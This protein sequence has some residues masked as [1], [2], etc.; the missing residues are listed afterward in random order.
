LVWNARTLIAMGLAMWLAGAAAAAENRY[1]DM[2]SAAVK[3][4]EVMDPSGYQ[5]GLLFNPEGYRS[6]YVRSACFQDAAVKFRDESL[7]ARVKERWSLLS[8][9]WG[10]SGRHCRQ[11][12]A[13]GAAAD[14]KALEETRSRYLQGAVALR[15]FRIERNGNGRDFDIVPS[16]EGGYAHG[17]TL[18]FEIIDAP[19][20]AGRVLLESSG[21]YLNGNDNI[22]VYV[23]LVDIRSRFPRFDLERSYR[24]RATLTLDVGTGGQSGMW[25]DAFIA[26]VFPIAERSKTLVN[27]VIFGNTVRR[28]ER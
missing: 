21:F 2:H 18:R 1:A 4:C 28:I 12:V 14:R 15:D 17:Y 27:D 10:Y 9:S 16:F 8:S 24:V 7:C 11:L 23:R 6:F 26:R 20:A 19:D 3:R 22:R 25:S 13:E 5:S